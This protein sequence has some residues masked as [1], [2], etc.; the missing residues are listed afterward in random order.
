M[1]THTYTHIPTKAKNFK[2]RYF[3]NFIKNISFII[4]IPSH[5]PPCPQ[6]SGKRETK[7]DTKRKQTKNNKP[8]DSPIQAQGC[9]RLRTVQCEIPL[10]D[11]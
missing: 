11:A 3:H 4:Y 8:K 6:Y 10:A 2:R 1:H 7:K 5:Q 9:G